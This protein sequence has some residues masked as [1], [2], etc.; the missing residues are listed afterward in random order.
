[1]T[2]RDR[3]DRLDAASPEHDIGVAPEGERA[4]ALALDG[5]AG[6]GTPD[7]HVDPDD[8][9]PALPF[10][11]AAPGKW[12]LA[13]SLAALR[14]QVDAMAPGRGKGRDGTI[15]DARHCPG[16]SDHCPTVRDGDCGVVTAIDITHD[17]G[18]GC[19][20]GAIAASIHASR[21]P[22]VKYIIWNGRIANSSPVKG[23][24]PW[25]WRDYGGPDPHTSHVHLSVKPGKDGPAGYDSKARWAVER[26][27]AARSGDPNRSS[28]PRAAT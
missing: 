3:R 7:P 4:K 26:G 23:T 20:A 18:E 2:Q 12:R 8:D 28:A 5:D 13:T 10:P 24:P 14:A 17:P 1:M 15:G 11:E 21:D 25:T 19:D 27:G 22:R 6:G 16:R 9:R